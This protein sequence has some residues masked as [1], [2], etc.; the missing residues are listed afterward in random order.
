MKTQTLTLIAA[1]ALVG[2]SS[3]FEDDNTDIGTPPGSDADADA[4]ADTDA[5][6]DA[7]GGIDPETADADGD[8]VSIADGDCD[9]ENDAVY[10]RFDGRDAANEIC[11]GIDN[12]CDDVIDEGYSKDTYFQDADDD[13]FGDEDEDLEACEEP[14]GYVDNGLDCNDDD[15]EVFPGATEIIG[16]GKDNDCDGEEDERFDIEEVVAEGDIGKPSV[17]RVDNAGRAH[18]VAHDAVTGE[19]VYLQVNAEGEMSEELVIVADENFDGAYL[20]AEIDETGKLHVSY[21]SDVDFS[22]GTHRSLWY[23]TRS[24]S[25]VWSAATLIDGNA[26][27]EFDRG[28]YVDMTLHRTEWLGNTPSF[29]YLNGDHGTAMLADVLLDGVDPVVFPMSTSYLDDFTGVASGLYTTMDVD[30][31]GRQHVAFY[32]PNA[33]FGFDPQIQYSDFAWNPDDVLG[34][35][36]SFGDILPSYGQLEETVVEA[37]ATDLSL[38]TRHEDNVPCIAYQDAGGRDL[39]FTCREGAGWTTETVWSEGLTGAHPS[40][41]INS[42]DEYFISFY[43]EGTMD[44]MLATKRKDTAWEIVTVDAEGMVGKESSIALG[45]DGRLHFSYYDQ[46]NQTVRYA[47]GF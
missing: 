25:G 29:A 43:D 18:I 12:D 28:Q 39:M 1:L 9:D 19:V 30:Q 21:T 46:T 26:S 6:A 41:L 24:S 3:K 23:T 34:A 36:G 7:D 33:G 8:G 5:D 44:L 14:D 22:T 35:G 10:P 45:P 47:V 32:D 31:E 15:D 40:L 27:G 42:A 20:D 38:K 2:C 37:N 16:D 17:V 4:D 13:G 11:D